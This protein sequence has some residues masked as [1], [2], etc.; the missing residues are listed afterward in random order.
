MV[1]TY[2]RSRYPRKFQAGQLRYLANLGMREAANGWRYKLYAYC[3]GP[4]Q[5][6]QERYGSRARPTGIVEVFTA[7]LE[8]VDWLREHQGHGTHVTHLAEEIVKP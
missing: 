8:A 7:S 5:A 1:R 2:K 4:A 3:H 6:C